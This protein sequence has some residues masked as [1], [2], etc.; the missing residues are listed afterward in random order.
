MDSRKITDI[1]NRR[2]YDNFLVH[3]KY[4]KREKI[5]GAKKGE[6][7]WKYYYSLKDAVEGAK[8]RAED[9]AN[10]VKSKVEAAANEA[11][12]KI[13]ES[14]EKVKEDIAEALDKTGEAVKE[15]VKATPK[16]VTSAADKVVQKTTEVANETG[17]KVLNKAI[18]YYD[19]NIYETDNYNIDTKKKQIELTEEW[20][21][22]VKRE[23]PE[24]VKKNPDGTKT[25]LLDEYLAKK[26]H[27]GLD[28]IDDL[29]NWRD[30][31]INKLD[32][33]ALAAGAKDYVDTAVMMVGIVSYALMTKFKISQGSYKEEMKAAAQTIENG[34]KYCN[35]I[36][37]Q[38][39][40]AYKDLKDNAGKIPTNVDVKA[41]EGIAMAVVTEAASE[42]LKETTKEAVKSAAQEVATNA[43]KEVVD[44]L[45]ERMRNSK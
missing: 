31:S 10:T 29:G 40:V 15:T 43:G 19:E 23:D 22:I 36:Y 24:Y 32:V 25:Y 20:K 45:E 8:T 18:D 21:D 11:K 3:W 37:Q 13:S 30:I 39:D 41:L 6:K 14:V 34:A 26:K 44:Y 27:P 9:V 7:Q 28:V 1:H 16:A 5:A 4:V 35:E 42:T 17:K 2:V 33:D 12:N 38:A